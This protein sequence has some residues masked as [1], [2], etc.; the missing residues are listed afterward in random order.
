MSKER[1]KGTIK[2]YIENK[3]FGFIN[4]SKGDLFFHIND[5][6][7]LPEHLIEE[8]LSVSYEIGEDQRTGKPKAFKL[9]IED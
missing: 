4:A 6:K 8:G 3:G 7:E 1:T 9:V 2:K 5:S